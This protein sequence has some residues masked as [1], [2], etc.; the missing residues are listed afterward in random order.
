MP[1]FKEAPNVI[2][3]DPEEHPFETCSECD[4]DI[5]NAI[6]GYY[7]HLK[8]KDLILCSECYQ[9]KVTKKVFL[10]DKV[11]VKAK[12]IQASIEAEV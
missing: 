12:W 3:G 2:T 10:V 11:K 4:R 6:E 8:I 5:D 9:D 1:F 7:G